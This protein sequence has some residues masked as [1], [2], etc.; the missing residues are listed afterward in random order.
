MKMIFA[1]DHIFYKYDG[2]FYSNGGLS[3]EVLRR[4]LNV[5]E[6]IS[7]LSRQKVKSKIV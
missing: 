5:F 7:L 2:N 4:Y 6:E 1:H 3:D